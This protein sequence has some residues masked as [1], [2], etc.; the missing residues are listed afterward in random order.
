MSFDSNDCGL[1]E[2]VCESEL[3]IVDNVRVIAPHS[4]HNA[5]EDGGHLIVLP[6]RHISTRWDLF[7]LESATMH[8]LSYI[9]RTA[10]S[11]ACSASWWNLQENGN[12][13]LG[14]PRGP[15]MHLHVYGRNVNSV[16]Q[17][18]G[19]AL[20]LP[21]RDANNVSLPMY[22]EKEWNRIRE[23][24]DC[25]SASAIREAATLWS[26]SNERWRSSIDASLDEQT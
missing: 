8:V 10:L 19:E 11:E 6:V 24:F 18:F 9:A 1:C 23:V 7:T 22:S 14:R 2:R 21:K 20:V 13:G 4:L 25:V 16:R 3:I 26:S 15:H 12:W 17:P 5:G